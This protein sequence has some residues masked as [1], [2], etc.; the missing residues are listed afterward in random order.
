[1]KTNSRKRVFAIV[2]RELI[3]IRRDQAADFESDVGMQSSLVADIGLDSISMVEAMIA[4]EQA[5]DIGE[6]SLSDSTD[7]EQRMRPAMVAVLYETFE[8]KPLCLCLMLRA[9][10]MRMSLPR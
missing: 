9:R 7:A 4:I 8:P 1:M 3:R 5:L 2:R 10:L 6:L